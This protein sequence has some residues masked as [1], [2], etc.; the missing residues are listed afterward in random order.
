MIYGTVAWFNPDG[1]S[2]LWDVDA[3]PTTT[4]PGNI[5]MP[6]LYWDK[7]TGLLM[8]VAACD[9]IHAA[10]D[11]TLYRST[12]G[13]RATTGL[14]GMCTGPYPCTKPHPHPQP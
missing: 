3:M 10:S 11:G 2:F 1:E 14:L 12:S 8:H 6:N 4:E 13:T 7:P 5:I 9:M